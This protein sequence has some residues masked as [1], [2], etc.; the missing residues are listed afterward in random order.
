MELKKEIKKERDEMMG[1]HNKSMDEIDKAKKKAIANIKKSMKNTT[2][3]AILEGV[4]FIEAGTKGTVNQTENEL[5]R[6]IK[7]HV[8]M[9]EAAASGQTG[10]VVS[11]YLSDSQNLM[12]HSKMLADAL[13]S[14][15]VAFGYQA[16]KDKS[17]GITLAATADLGGTLKDMAKAH[18][19]VL[20]DWANTEQLALK[21]AVSS[22]SSW[23]LARH[24]LLNTWSRVTGAFGNASKAEDEA[25]ESLAMTQ[26]LDLL[27]VDAAKVVE[28]A[29]I[30]VKKGMNSA[31]TALY[32]SNAVK[33][34]T[35]DR[36]TA[37]TALESQVGATEQVVST[38]AAQ[39][40]AATLATD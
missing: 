22:T 25:H 27:T 13:Q 1:K 38:A 15:V 19:D 34:D 10:Q 20:L 11:S 6:R 37:I 9:S 17:P 26:W 8:Q 5:E 14:S 39:S 31:S 4:K 32:T 18:H 7:V 29:G 33:K 35:G 16:A 2:D 23:L 24:E 21:D 40:N 36:A 30:A 28:K 3:E 12:G